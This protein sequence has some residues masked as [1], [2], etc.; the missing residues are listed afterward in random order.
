MVRAR[1]PSHERP[2]GEFSW[3]FHPIGC[4]LQ[5]IYQARG[6]QTCVLRHFDPGGHALGEANSRW[7]Y[8]EITVPLNHRKG[9]LTRQATFEQSVMRVIEEAVHTES[10]EGWEPDSPMEYSALRR[11]GRIQWKTVFNV[12]P[13]GDM[14]KAVSASIRLKRLSRPRS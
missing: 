1:E 11:E 13:L 2:R 14:N 5:G 9:V 7:T 10:H 4:A 3:T 6:A 12:N 8:K